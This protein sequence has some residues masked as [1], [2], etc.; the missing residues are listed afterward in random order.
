MRATP[1]PL[2][3]CNWPPTGVFSTSGLKCSPS[4]SH[5]RGQRHRHGLPSSEPTG[6]G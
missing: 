4:P 6:A 5:G 3:A 2:S 1:C